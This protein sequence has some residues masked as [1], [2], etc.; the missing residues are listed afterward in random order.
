MVGTASYRGYFNEAAA[1]RYA[2]QWEK[3]GWDVYV[4]GVE[5]YSTLGWF[6][7]PLMN[8]FIYEPEVDLAETIFHELGHRRLFI[9]G[10]TDFNE[11]FATEVAA[12]GLRRWFAA[13]SNPKA[14]VKHLEILARE[15]QFVQL[16]MGTRQEL[17]AVYGDGQL[18][19]TVKLQRKEEI[20]GKM[21]ARY[22]A[23][24]QEW[25]GNTGY[26]EWFAEPINNAKLNTVSA[27][28]ELTPAFQALLRAQGGDME[29]F[30]EA[31]AALG[32]LPIEKRHETLREYLKEGPPS[33]KSHR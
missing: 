23:V 19:E 22:A 3:K 27:Y 12:E 21:R 33:D 13:S 9:N 2:A 10:D 29:K 26:D 14:Y 25:G 31:V 4:D 24:K 28:Y 6:R 30:Y 7:D 18:P 17:E 16:V 5:A 1:R 11:A 8:T 32:K 20:I 15:K